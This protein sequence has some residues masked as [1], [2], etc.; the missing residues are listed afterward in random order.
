MLHHSWN[1][2]GKPTGITSSADAVREMKAV[3]RTDL[4]PELCAIIEQIPD[5]APIEHG[6]TAYWVTQPWDNHNGT[7]T[8]LG[9]ACHPMLPC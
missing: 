9:D 2:Q 8:L 6:K 3:A 1:P 5:D 7:V 4:A